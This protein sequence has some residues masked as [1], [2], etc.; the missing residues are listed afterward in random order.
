MANAGLIS[1]SGLARLSSLAWDIGIAIG[2]GDR[3]RRDVAPGRQARH[4]A[5][6][7]AEDDPAGIA[8]GAEIQLV[9]EGGCKHLGL[10]DGFTVFGG[11]VPPTA[12]RFFAR[13]VFAEFSQNTP[14][15]SPAA[16]IRDSAIWFPYFVVA[17]HSHLAY[18]CE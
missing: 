18:Y 14:N 10:F 16:G 13:V 9:R 5:G 2:R 12:K 7:P 4:F 11:Q 3:F 8:H 17:N 6:Q 15:L 1:A